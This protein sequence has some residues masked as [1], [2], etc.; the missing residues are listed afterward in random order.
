[1]LLKCKQLSISVE[2]LVPKQTGVAQYLQVPHHER[3]LCPWKEKC[4]KEKQRQSFSKSVKNKPCQQPA[5]LKISLYTKIVTI[6]VGLDERDD[7]GDLKY[8]RGK[9]L[10][11]KVSDKS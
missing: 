10:P 8:I 4:G 6:T 9:R 11:V 3:E 5:L 1:M 7:K 2:N